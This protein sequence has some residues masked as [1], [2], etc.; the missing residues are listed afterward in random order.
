M[1]GGA[2]V[3]EFSGWKRLDEWTGGSIIVWS[4]DGTLQF[5]K[6]SNNVFDFD[7]ELHTVDTRFVKLAFT[8]SH[9]IPYFTKR[10][11]FHVTDAARAQCI[12]RLNVPV[13]GSFKPVM[14]LFSS[15]ETRLM[16]MTQADGHVCEVTRNGRLVRFHFKKQRKIER[17]EFLLKT[18]EI[19]YKKDVYDGVTNIFIPWKDAPVCMRTAKQFCGRLMEH[20]PEVFIDE[21]KRWDGYVDKRNNADGFEYSTTN[22]DNADWVAVMAHLSGNAAS[23]KV[24]DRSDKGWSKAYR[25]YVRKQTRATVRGKD[26]YKES[27]TG[28]VYCPTTPTGFFMV[29]Y[30]GRIH[31]TGNSG[32]LIQ[33]QNFPRGAFSDIDNCLEAT[34]AGGLD[35]VQYLWGEP[36]TAASTCLRGIL[37]AKP[38]HTLVSADFASIEARV[39]AWVAGEEHVLESFRSGLDLYKVAAAGIF[40]CEYA[41]VTKQQRQ[42]GKVA[43]LALGFAGGIGAFASMARNYAV[44]LEALPDLVFKSG[45]EEDLEVSRSLAKTYLAAHKNAGMSEDAATAC[46]LI[47]RLWRAAHPNITRLWKALENCAAQAVRNPGEVASYRCLAFRV[48]GNFLQMRLPSGRKLHYYSPAFMTVTTPWGAEK[49][50]VTAEAVDSLSKKWRRRPYPG[51]LYCENGIQAISRDL[52]ALAML[53]VEAAGYPVV[54]SVHDELVSEV[55]EGFGSLEEY[56]RLMAMTPAWAAGLPVSAEGWVGSRYRK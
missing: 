37:R 44:N 45:T 27:Y 18:A 54:L 19:S 34:A 8:E 15:I 43:S 31:I 33:P 39:T 36:M 1:P 6:S 42:L 50:M 2:E 13:S 46:D 23:I 14:S 28:K 32:R 17:C 5:G 49:E 56:E 40:G 9:K 51:G 21:I 38:G 52:M 41:D 25:V 35:L 10:G 55:P 30:K 20:D 16:V 4:P 11:N 48:Q 7:G 47:K 12:N 29:R 24:I 22:K 26:F 53:R 3:L